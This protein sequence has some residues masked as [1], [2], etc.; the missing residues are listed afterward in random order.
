MALGFAAIA[1]VAAG[2]P[3][4]QIFAQDITPDAL[5]ALQQRA[6]QNQ[7]METV[8]PTVQ[9]YQPTAPVTGNAVPTSRLELRYSSRAGRPLVQI[10]YDFLGAPSA[11]SVVQTGTMSD[12]YLLGQGDE[13]VVTLRG[14][15]NAS[16]RLNV[17]R[18]G[19]VIL[20]K[21][22][23]ILAAGRTFGE[24]RRELQALVSL[25]YV[26]TDAF[27]TLGAVHQFSVVVAGAVRSPG[28]RI[29]NSLTTVL[30]SILL[31][32]G[33]DKS[34]SLRSVQ[35]IRN[36]T[37]RIVDL[38]SVI[39]KGGNSN[40][41]ILQDGDRVFVPPLGATVAIAGSV[42]QPGIYELPRGSSEIGAN[43]LI[44]LAGGTLIAD[45]YNLS[46]ATLDMDGATRLIP[47][48]R[49]ASIKSGE[50]LFLDP[51]R[52]ADRDRLAIAGAV[53]LPGDRPLSLA[54]STGELFRNVDDLLPT[55]YAPFAIVVRRD[56]NTN[57]TSL[58]P[59]RR[60]G[61]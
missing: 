20:P 17:D 13:L 60:S 39:L 25:S 55:A 35:L 36:G 24:F 53:Q 15:E 11:V 3:D 29:V 12:N 16:Y 43:A 18:D 7:G 28:A 46:K 1:L 49:Y 33:I 34:G 57:A 44:S 8:K 45:S 4:Q 21:L 23:P 22:K 19:R 6:G 58:L 14:Q 26:S 51:N 59:F 31:S 10:G 52:I 9:T 50:V 40:P 56:T 47:M 5:K 61:R 48:S 2:L 32:G 27:V 54:H 37:I 38:Y 42:R 41:L 30:D